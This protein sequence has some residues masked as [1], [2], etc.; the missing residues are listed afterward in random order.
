MK[1]VAVAVAVVAAVFG[2]AAIADG[3]KPKPKQKPV[4]LQVTDRLG[5]DV[6]LAPFTSG[7]ATVA[8]PSGYLASGGGVY[9]G[10]VEIAYD[11]PTESGRGWEAAGI[12]A[13]DVE[14]YGFSVIVRCV[15][16]SNK[17]LRVRGAALTNAQKLEK[18]R[19]LRSSLRG[20]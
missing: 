4:V 20:R 6:A 17:N 15:K 1:R 19:E 8:C 5:D 14:P 18:V 13:S 7:K 9:Q 2:T 11:G 3:A 10:A 16:G 12:N